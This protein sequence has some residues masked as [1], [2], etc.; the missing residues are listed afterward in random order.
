MSIDGI[1]DPSQG[2]EQQP[3]SITLRDALVNATF[4]NNRAMHPDVKSLQLGT[5]GREAD[6]LMELTLQHPQKVEY[7]KLIY[8]TPQHTLLVPT[9]PVEGTFRQGNGTGGEVAFKMSISTFPNRRTWA[10]E[11][12]QDRFVVTAMHTHSDLD[13]PPSPQDMLNLFLA[14]DN[15]KA[16]TAVFVITKSQKTDGSL[17]SNKYILFRGEHTPQWTDAQANEKVQQWL[18]ML[19]ERVR[20]H[21]S[22]YMSREE[23]SAINARAQGALMRHLVRAYDLRLFTAINGSEYAVEAT[24]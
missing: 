5:L 18:K 19:T 17:T 15:I 7:G 22:P 8:A 21:L 20:A 6:E 23:Q 16:Q 4:A 9:V 3:K 10:K 12:R 2:L 1:G 14:D 13:F 24:A 11:Q